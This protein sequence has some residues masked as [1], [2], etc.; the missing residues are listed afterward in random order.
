MANFEQY[1]KENDVV[2][3]D[4]GMSTALE[5]QGL[6]M[7]NPVWNGIG[8]IAAPKLVEKAHKEFLD[9]GANVIITD[10]YFCSSW[11]FRSLGFNTQ[12]SRD[13]LALA[14][15]LAR[16]AVAKSTGS[17][18]KFVAGGISCYGVQFSNLSEYTGDYD[19]PDSEYRAHHKERMDVFVEK[20]V[21]LFAIETIPNFKESVVLLDL[22]KEYP[23]MKVYFSSTLSDSEH[24]GDGTPYS[25]LQPL[26]EE[27]PQILAYGANCVKP[28]L[29]KP[30]LEFAGKKAKK[31]FV[32]YPNGFGAYDPVAKEFTGEMV[33]FKK[34]FKDEAKEW[35]SLGCKLIGGC[36]GSDAADIKVLAD[37]FK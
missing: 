31:P 18:E 21:D 23:D 10:T 11:I 2:I 13:Y 6:T 27:H 14:V 4:G 34:L 25:E 33:D 9:A 26:L 15:D 28:E 32:A 3:L 29:I 20:G 12:E 8:L 24:L 19:V 36:C 7:S 35:K 16:N 30:F 1:L 17:Q 5:E 22:L 37:V